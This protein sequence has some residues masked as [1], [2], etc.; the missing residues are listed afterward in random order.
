MHRALGL[1]AALL[2]AGT[3]FAPPGSAPEI[4][5]G[6]LQINHANTPALAGRAQV[7]AGY[8]AISNEG[9]HPDSLIGVEVGFAAK[10]MLHTTGFNADGVASMKHVQ[11][12]EIPAND[13]VVLEPGGYHIM[14]MGLTQPLTVGDMMPA[15]LIFEQ[16]GRV[17][18][19]SFSED[20]K[21]AIAMQTLGPHV[22]VSQDAR[23]H[24]AAMPMEERSS[25]ACSS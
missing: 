9:D 1:V 6:E 22:T 3:A 10:A 8:M 20:E 23:R 18:R 21:R 2:L 24:G 15:T 14:L 16:A 4:G 13:T 12:L 11:A 17:Q 7:A 25:P 19:R 5:M